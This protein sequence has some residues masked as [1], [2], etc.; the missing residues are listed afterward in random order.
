MRRSIDAVSVL[1]DDL[2]DYDIISD[3]QRS[4]ESSITDLGPGYGEQGERIREPSPSQEAK[5]LFRTAGSSAE[6]IQDY[7]QRA[8]GGPTGG[9]RIKE[10]VARVYVDGFWDRLQ[11][12]YTRPQTMRQ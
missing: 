11:T 5:E 2:A 10:G 3:G 9:R 4:L 1:S 7:V 8:L 12:R 6:E